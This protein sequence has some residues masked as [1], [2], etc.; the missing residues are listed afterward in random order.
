M[1]RQLL[2]DLE[3]RGFV[4]SCTDV[5]GLA[6]EMN[7][8]PIVV[9]AGFDPTADSLHVGN[10]TTLMLLRQFKKAG[11]TVL[12]L[13]GGATG[14]VGDPT[15]KDKTRPVLP[16]EVFQNNIA[17]VTRSIRAVLG[18]DTEILDN[19]S[20]T[21]PLSLL[22]FLSEIGSK[23]SISR[24]LSLES[25]KTRLDREIPMTFQEFTYSL[26]QGMDFLRLFDMR[27]V[28]LQV[29]GSDQWGN[30]TMGI[31]LIR[32]K[33]G[34]NTPV[35][36]LTHPLLTTANGKKMGKSEKGAVWLNPPKDGFNCGISDFDFW[37][38]WR[39]VA[40]EDALRLA[41][42]FTDVPVTDLEKQAEVNVNQLKETL[43]TAVTA[44]ARG[45]DAAEECRKAARG[46]FSGSGDVSGLPVVNAQL[47]AD[48]VVVAVSAGLASSKSEARRLM[49]QNGI[50]I[51]GN[52]VKE[53]DVV[54]QHH[55][56]KNNQAVLSRGKKQHVVIKVT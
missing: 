40:D 20:W 47:G 42:L 9:Y 21:S 46:V 10:L 41:K 44:V 12:P 27:G 2:H 1:N 23:I 39:N 22:N 51:N 19:T 26:L 52:P 31:E 11:H 8:G 25:V 7:K 14:R 37:Q 45:N 13:I 55:L 4:H 16:P 35:F 50:R 6:A 18:E 3:S 30:I 49:N 32:K 43:A 54:S 5:S 29:G 34:Q 24:M 56:D 53:G 33:H 36:G 28:C 15:G 17:G 38:F 48:L